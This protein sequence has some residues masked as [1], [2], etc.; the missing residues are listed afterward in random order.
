[1]T[2]TYFFPTP[3]RT[4]P[5]RMSPPIPSV[6]QDW[7]KSQEQAEPGLPSPVAELEEPLALGALRE[8]RGE[9]RE[10]ARPSEMGW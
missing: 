4:C 9:R 1:M 2:G 3:S 8:H 10:E 7:G 5:W 6:F